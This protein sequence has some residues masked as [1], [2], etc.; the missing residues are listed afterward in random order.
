MDFIEKYLGDD[1]PS[2][3]SESS[4]TES[5]QVEAS[6]ADQADQAS[7][8]Q[9][10]SQSDEKSLSEMLKDVGPEE[11]QDDFMQKINELGIIRNGL[12]AEFNSVDEI[13]EMLSKGYDYTVKT[14]ELSKQ[15]EEV[16]AQ[17]G[18]QRQEFEQQK[19]EFETYKQSVQTE[20][21]ANNVMLEVLQD[22][23]NHDPDTYNEIVR[24]F[25]QRLG[26]YTQ[27]INNPAV[28][29]LET[30]ISSLKDALK[31]FEGQK[32][33]EQNSRVFE[34]WENGLK[35]FQKEHLSKFRSLGINPDYKK[36][37]EI[38]ANDVSNKMT[39]DQA[40]WAVHGDALQKQLESKAK[41]EA[42]RRKSDQ[43]LGQDIGQS[44][45]VNSENNESYM[46]TLMRISQKYA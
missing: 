29:N 27:S 19:Q 45:T 2:S 44:K 21:V 36:I 42:T 25:Q 43:R 26:A 41:L 31:K 14:K 7:G 38:W 5:N 33:E 39:F 6:H 34:E 37:Q 9:V 10:Q 40:V 4:T 23:Q 17:I 1:N 46:D 24:N 20:L 13:K 3:E 15:R 35:Q 18:Q 28:K 22:F 11:K 32:V 30:E 16:E 12:P 8:E